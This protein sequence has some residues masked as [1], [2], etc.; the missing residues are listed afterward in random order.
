MEDKERNN[1]EEEILMGNK[2]VSMRIANEVMKSICKVI[3]NNNEEQ[4]FG[5]GFFM[6]ISPLKYLITNYHVINPNIED[7]IIQI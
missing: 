4:A 5:T 6:K 3:I 1:I 2:P 7:S